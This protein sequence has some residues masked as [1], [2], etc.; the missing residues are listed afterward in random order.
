MLCTWKRAVTEGQGFRES[1]WKGNWVTQSTAVENS[2]CLGTSNTAQHTA[3]TDGSFSEINLSGN[4]TSGFKITEW[5]FLSISRNH[6]AADKRSFCALYL[7]HTHRLCYNP[8]CS[9]LIL[10]EKD[11]LF[12][13]MQ[14]LIP[15]ERCFQ[16]QLTYGG[17][18][19]GG[20]LPVQTIMKVNPEAIILVH[21]LHIRALRSCWSVP[22]TKNHEAESSKSWCCE[23]WAANYLEGKQNDSWDQYKKGGWMLA[24]RRISLSVCTQATWAGTRFPADMGM[25]SPVHSLWDVLLSVLSTV[26]FRETATRN[27]LNLYNFKQGVYVVKTEGAAL[28]NSTEKTVQSHYSLLDPH[29]GLFCFLF[30]DCT[31]YPENE[32]TVIITF[33]ITIILCTK[34]KITKREGSY[35]IPNEAILSIS[36]ASTILTKMMERKH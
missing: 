34:R 24:N 8:F 11:I 33:I 19:G 27:L 16:K 13:N 18:G 5:S 4:S 28:K 32:S 22:T 9:T 20:C 29:S 12:L 1:V 10:K 25:R 31:P 21:A 6:E 35:Q 23:T 30:S 26:Y 17:R 15:E 3:T 2:I 7:T 14:C 36:A